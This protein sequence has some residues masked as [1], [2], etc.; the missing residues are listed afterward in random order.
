MRPFKKKIIKSQ[1]KRA[2][3]EE[4]KNYENTTKAI[5]KMALRKQLSIIALN[6]NFNNCLNV[7]VLIT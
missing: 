7:N 2:K 4:K 5:S 3:E 1:I 6:V